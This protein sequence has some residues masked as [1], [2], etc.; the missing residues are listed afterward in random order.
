MSNCENLYSDISDKPTRNAFYVLAGLNI[1]VIIQG[2]YTFRLRL[3]N[4][5]QTYKYKTCMFFFA[6][7]SCLIVAEIYFVTGT[8]KFGKCGQNFI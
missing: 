8:V 5:S 3:K 4:D 6:A 1:L 7:L 2:F